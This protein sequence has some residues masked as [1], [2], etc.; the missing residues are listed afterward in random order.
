MAIYCI[1]LTDFNKDNR[2]ERTGG[3]IVTAIFNLLGN[4]AETLLSYRCSGISKKISVRP[5]RILWIGWWR[6]VIVHTVMRALQ[7][8]LAWFS[9]QAGKVTLW[10]VPKGH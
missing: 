3:K 8:L 5:D 2:N 6:T 1:Q 4:E 7:T 9:S 10:S